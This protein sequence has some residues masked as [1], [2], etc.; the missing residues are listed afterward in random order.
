MTR[1]QIIRILL[2]GYFVFAAI[3]YFVF[4]H[5]SYSSIR[6]LQHELA[7]S[8]GTEIIRE[9]QKRAVRRK[10]K[11]IRRMSSVIRDFSEKLGTYS[12]QELVRIIGDLARKHRVAVSSFEIGG[13]ENVAACQAYKAR[14]AVSSRRF[15]Q[16]L[17]FLV[18]LEQEQ[19]RFFW[20]ERL[21]LNAQGRED[22]E[23]RLKLSMMLAADLRT[24]TA[25]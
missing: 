10:D 13:K 12:Q 17:S 8:S 23:Y 3:I 22:A 24:D 2:G 15:E 9:E 14:M 20:I 4:I 7:R 1:K 19:D 16:I 5:G 6:R 21:E 18:A 11:Q 25:L